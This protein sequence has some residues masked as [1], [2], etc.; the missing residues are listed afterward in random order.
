VTKVLNE[1]TASDSVSRWPNILLQTAPLHQFGV[2]LKAVT[3]PQVSAIFHM[4]FESIKSLHLKLPFYME[5]RNL[6]V[7]FSGG[8]KPN[9]SRM[10]VRTLLC[11]IK[12]ILGI[13]GFSLTIL[14]TGV[15]LFFLSIWAL[16]VSSSFCVGSHPK[17]S[18]KIMI[19][20]HIANR[21]LLS[22]LWAAVSFHPDTCLPVGSDK[23]PQ[24][25]LNTVQPFSRAPGPQK[26]SNWPRG[27]RGGE[28]QLN[29]FLG[30]VFSRMFFC[31]SCRI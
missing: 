27:R 6:V 10:C 16:F 30:K 11:F 12:P 21:A 14:V 13:L 15:Q 28:A 17:W 4:I 8:L 29:A 23:S 26:S 25:R 3:M 7:H 2:P 31:L 5:H 22:S 1:T 9:L 19:P 24:S 18:H 20:G